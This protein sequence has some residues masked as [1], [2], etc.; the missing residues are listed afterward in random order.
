MQTWAQFRAPL[1]AQLVLQQKEITRALEEAEHY[2]SPGAPPKAV[3]DAAGEEGGEG[4]GGQQPATAMVKRVSGAEADAL[5]AKLS[6]INEHLAQHSQEVGN[7]CEALAGN[8]HLIH[9]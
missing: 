6:S 9:A 7:S 1:I 4:G 8:L 3:A 5:R 2:A